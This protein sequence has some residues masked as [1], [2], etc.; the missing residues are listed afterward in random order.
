LPVALPVTVK[1][2]DTDGAPKAG[3]PVY[4]FSGGAYTGYHGTSDAD[5]QVVFT[6]PEGDYR[7]RADYDG[8]QFWSGMVN[9]CTIPGCLE[10]LVEIPGGVGGPVSV[11]IDYS[12]DPLQRLIAADYSTGEFFHY[13]YDAV[14]NRL[15]QDTLAGTNSYDYDIANRLIG[16]TRLDPGGSPTNET[17]FTY[18][19]VGNRL[20][21]T[22]DGV[23]T[24][25]TYNSLDQ[26]LTAGPRAF[27]YDA[28]GNLTQTST[29]AD[30]TTYSWDA[31]DRLSDATLPDGTA[32]AYTYDADGRRV[33]QL[34]GG[35]ET[36]CLWDEA[37]LYGDV[38]LETDASGA[39]LPAT[40][41]ADLS[42]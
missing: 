30:V 32:L 41:L 11:T 37:S 8:V 4:A 12:Y 33:S 13:S 34:V 16:E 40:F 18:D 15:T 17:T 21:M 9:H 20:R 38:V 36:N 19:P 26:L 29:G 5:G 7:F 25:Y 42:C 24:N 22:V 35:A 14:G 6:L 2:Q 28:R 27:A 3:L 31:L 1:L 23:T 39:A 10:A